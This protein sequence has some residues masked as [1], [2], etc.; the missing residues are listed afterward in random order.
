MSHSE[1]VVGQLAF[2]H[3]SLSRLTNGF[4]HAHLSSLWG[5]ILSG[6]TYE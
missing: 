6:G 5:M 4:G 3:T 1:M 2:L